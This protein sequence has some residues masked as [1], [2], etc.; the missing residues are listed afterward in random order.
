MDVDRLPLLPA[1]STLVDVLRSRALSQPDGAAY[2]YLAD[3]ES[4]ELRLT[5]GEL[6]A[7]ARRIAAALRHL[8][9]EG[10]RALL[11]Y[12]PGLDY[13][14]AFFGCLYAGVVGVCAYPPPAVRGRRLLPRLRAIVSDSRARAALTTREMLAHTEEFL[15]GEGGLGDLHWLTTDAPEVLTTAPYRA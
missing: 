10:E 1:A 15:A 8:G 14:K 9:L 12:P 5:Y 7:E 3:G 4:R 6:A 2:V 13:I 11:L